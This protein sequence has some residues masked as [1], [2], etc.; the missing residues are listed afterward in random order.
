MKKKLLKGLFIATA[1]SIFSSCSSDD[2]D[3]IKPDDSFASS[4][5]GMYILNQGKMGDN[6]ANMGYYDQ[7]TSTVTPKIFQSQNDGLK[8]GETA[9]DMIVYGSKMYISIT[10]SN[11]IYVTDLN[12]KLLKGTDGK[13]TIITLNNSQDIPQQ[14]HS[15]IAYKGNVYATFYGGCVAR[16]DTTSLAIDKQVATEAYPEKMTIVNNNLYVTNRSGYSAGEESTT[17]SKIDLTAFSSATKITVAYNPTQ[18]T[19]DASGTIYVAGWGQFG[20]DTKPAT[21]Q[22]IDSETGDVSSISNLSVTN[23]VVKNDKVL[24]IYSDPITYASSLAYYDITNNKLETQSFVSTEK[25]L[26][27]AQT[28]TIDPTNSNI[29]ITMS[30]FMTEGSVNIYSASGEFM[31]SIDTGGINPIGVYFPRISK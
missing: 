6:N 28:I 11:R 22:K 24:L 17:I 18:I 16:I 14:P 13:E 10:G 21:F 29:Y 5:T 2:N 20:D 31:K 19:S 3:N 8:L 25:P 15:L 30:D 4:K 12:C 7:A 27:S 26:S 1:V 9:Q 23:M